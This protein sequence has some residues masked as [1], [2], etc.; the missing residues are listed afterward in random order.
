L[1]DGT[2]TSRVYLPDAHEVGRGILVPDA[3]VSTLAAALAR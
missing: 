1:A 3:F 2:Q